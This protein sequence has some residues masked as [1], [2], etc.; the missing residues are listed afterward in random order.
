M[1]KG[2]V[3]CWY[4][5]CSYKDKLNRF[6]AKSLQINLRFSFVHLHLYAKDHE[7]AY[8]MEKKET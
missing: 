3:W 5:A 4:E 6:C 1:L 7:Y 2:F 8:K